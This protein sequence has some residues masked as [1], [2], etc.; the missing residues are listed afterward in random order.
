M[1]AAM[2]TFRKRRRH[3]VQLMGLFHHAL[4]FLILCLF[5]LEALGAPTNSEYKQAQ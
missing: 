4:A 3:Y 1:S 2:Y 5:V